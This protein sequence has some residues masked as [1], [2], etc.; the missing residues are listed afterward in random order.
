MAAIVFLVTYLR[1]N[2]LKKRIEECG[3]EPEVR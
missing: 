2:W 3:M 1:G